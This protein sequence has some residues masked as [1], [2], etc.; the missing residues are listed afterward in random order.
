MQSSEQN[1][2][3]FEVV[4]VVFHI[5]ADHLEG[6]AVYYG[7]VEKHLVLLKL[8]VIAELLGVSLV[9]VEPGVKPEELVVFLVILTREEGIHDEHPE[10][11]VE[12]PQ[13]DQR[14]HKRPHA[15][16]VLRI[17]DALHD[18]VGEGCEL[19]VDALVLLE[20][21]AD[22]VHLGEEDNF[23]VEVER[24]LV[25]PVD[26]GTHEVH[27]GQLVDVV[28]ISPVFP[29]EVG[30]VVVVVGRSGQHPVAILGPFLTILGFR[31]GLR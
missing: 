10:V 20:D 3:F 7:N 14:V 1:S 18:A 2:A 30:D 27:V 11:L 24:V 22:V 8:E 4:N 31:F 12:V 19:S 5:L 29:L 6:V 26:Q 17:I 25:L 23:F 16:E 28:P 15:D 21:I 13:I 9:L